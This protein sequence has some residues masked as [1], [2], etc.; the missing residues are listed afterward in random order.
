M[1]GDELQ[2]QLENIRLR[3]LETIADLEDEALLQPGAIGSWSVRDFLFLL[4]NW[5]SELVTALRQIE[6]GKKPQRLLKALADRDAYNRERL[7]E[8]PD[9]DLDQVFDDLQAVRLELEDWLTRFK[10]SELTNPR[11]YSWLGGKSLS[12]LVV[13]TSFGYEARFLLHLE[14]FADQWLQI[15]LVDLENIEVLDHDD[16]RKGNGVSG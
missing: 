8:I 16:P 3:L 7:Q 11:R 9:R 12:D 2:E 6:G 14:L 4:S 1:N 10:D 5:E 15:P 13:E